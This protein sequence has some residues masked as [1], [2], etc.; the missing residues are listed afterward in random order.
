MCITAIRRVTGI[1]LNNKI[2][3]TIGETRPNTVSLRYVCKCYSH[4]PHDQTCPIWSPLDDG[5]DPLPFWD[6]PPPDDRV[7]LHRDCP[8]FWLH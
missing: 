5:G 4:L 7:D 2:V 6:K 8:G 3:R 1:G